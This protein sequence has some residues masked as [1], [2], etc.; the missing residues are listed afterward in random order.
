MSSKKVLEE[1]V[2]RTPRIRVDGERWLGVHLSALETFAIVS[3]WPDEL[4]KVGRAVKPGD[5]V[6]LHA[7]EAARVRVVLDVGRGSDAAKS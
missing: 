2:S 7:R 5:L 3:A 4:G 1:S 6:V